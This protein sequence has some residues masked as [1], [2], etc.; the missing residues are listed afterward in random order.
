MAYGTRARNEVR[1]NYI[2]KLLPLTQAAK[3]AG[4]KNIATARRWKAEALENGDDW[5]K[6]KAAASIA[7][8]GRDDLIKTMIN[9][10]VV[11]HQSVMDSLKSPDCALTAKDKVDALAS[12]ADAFAK[13]MKSAGMASPELSKLSIATEVIQLLGDFVRDD[14][15]Q[16]AAAFI[17]ILEPFG[18]E[19]T[20]HYG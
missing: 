6:L 9:D 18:E 1:K 19:L 20:K 4:I 3:L 8:G 17:E 5:D 10:Y 13:T 11:F 2:F 16:H 14:F 12:L 15:P 7:S